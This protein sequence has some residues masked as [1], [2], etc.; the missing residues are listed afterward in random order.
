M[1]IDTPSIEKP[2]TKRGNT[3]VRQALFN[4][5]SNSNP[6]QFCP[7]LDFRSSKLDTRQF[8]WYLVHAHIHIAV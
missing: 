2:R 4:L 1:L 8:G 5:G 3:K 6:F 7:E